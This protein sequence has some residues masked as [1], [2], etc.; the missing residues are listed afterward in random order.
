LLPFTKKQKK[1][2]IVESSEEVRWNLQ[3]LLEKNNYK[4]TIAESG[5]DG[6][7]LAI[8]NHP[9]L[10]IADIVIPMM[11]GLEMLKLVRENSYTSEIPFI[12]L[13][14]R[15]ATIDRRIGM[16]SG[17]DDYIAIPFKEDD[18]LNSIRIRLAK[19]ENIDKKFDKVFRSIS[20]NIPHELRT[21]LGSIIG[22][23]NIMLDEFHELDKREM[24]E[25]LTN[26]KYSALR[27]HKTVEK[28]IVFSEAEVLNMD[29]THNEPLLAKDTE[30]NAFLLFSI[31]N[32][33][34]N[35]EETPPEINLNTTYGKILVA[36]EHFGIMFGE[37]IDNAIKFSYPGKPIDVSTDEEESFFTISIKNSGRGMTEDEIKSIAPFNQH[38]RQ[39]YEQQGNGLGLMIVSSLSNFY[40]I[41]FNLT[42]VQNEC[43]VASLR[44]RKQNLDK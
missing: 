21:P 31:I 28:F 12:F 25:M 37:L 14:E 15:A 42:S 35:K 10:I 5:Y 24:F 20:G 38:N 27:L 36:E 4:V 7:K 43:T 16:N 34:I 40:N 18:I 39:K 41:K 13:T 2:L 26:I 30:I 3:V 23:T 8:N 22:F 11:N 17:A 9:D 6:Y 19:K 33:K 32:E 1:I 44:F 29:K